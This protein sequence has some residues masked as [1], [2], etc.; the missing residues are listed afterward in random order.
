MV[1]DGSTDAT[2]A[3][4]QEALSSASRTAEL[5]IL[6]AAH[7]GKGSAVALGLGEARGAIHVVMDADLSVPLQ[8]LDELVSALQSGADIAIG[9]RE[10]PGAQRLGEPAYRHLMG[11]TFNR[12]VTLAG[13]RGVPDTQCGFKALRSESTEII[14]PRLRLYPAA[15]TAVRASRVTAYD[16]ELLA[17]AQHHAL[18]IDQ[19]PVTWRYVPESKV[20][21]VRDAAVMLWDIV[22]LRWH[23]APGHY[24]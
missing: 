19:I 6:R 16:V 20:R 15:A 3:A 5:S 7:R 10:L 21:P 13:V 9:S 17:I 22:R 1:D 12:I 4:A 18:R 24:Q 8:Y 14:L 23:V 2:A 11:R